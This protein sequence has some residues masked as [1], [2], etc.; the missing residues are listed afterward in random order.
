[1][2]WTFNLQ[3][4]DI[5]FMGPRFTW[6]NNRDNEGPN[7]ERLVRSYATEEWMNEFPETFIRNLPIAHSD[8][9]P[10]FLQTQLEP[11]TTRRPYQIENWSLH[12]DEVKLMVSEIWALHIVGS[13]AYSLTRRLHIIRGR[14][15]AWCLDKK[16]SGA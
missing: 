12:Y 16:Y 6:S 7:M 3:L 1:M 5:P 15:K 4:Q 14:L 13:P 9:G 11:K 10:I 8:H 2:Q